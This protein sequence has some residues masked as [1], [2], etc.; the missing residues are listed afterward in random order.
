[1]ICPKCGF[2]QPDDIYCALC[3]VNIERYAHQKRKRRFKTCLLIIAV[4]V[5][6][7]TAASFLTSS[8]TNERVNKVAKDKARMNPALLTQTATYD[9]TSRRE[10]SPPPSRQRSRAL[11]DRGRPAAEQKGPDASLGTTKAKTATTESGKGPSTAIEWFEKGAKLDDDSDAEI[12]CYQKAKELDPTFAP[13]SFRL[14]AIYYREAKYEM[15]DE[16][17]SDFLKNASEQDKETYNI[18]EFY[19]LADVENLTEAISTQAK[20]GNAEKSPTSE[21]KK[22][23]T[24][25]KPSESLDKLPGTPGEEKETTEEVMT[26]VGFSQVD[27]QIM[28]PVLF[29]QSMQA[30]VLVDTGAGITVLS[31][32]LAQE[33][34]LDMNTARSVTLKT[35]AADV[36]ANLGRLDAIQVG[37]LSRQDFPVAIANLPPG[38]RGN[39][40]G[41]LG[42]DFM[43][44]YTIHIDNENSI[45]TLTPKTP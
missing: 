10:A 20:T 16:A 34:G 36:Q 30:R 1:M 18:Y 31:T 45:I 42:M 32:E 27:G 39:F 40:Q 3:G 29:N 43:N 11:R 8:P 7:V 24:E 15:A 41:I 37:T 6:G 14:G 23:T 35:M 12:E 9:N 5:G 2:S 44:H 25:Q 17:F 4:A 19:S 26:V 13:A 21:E 33:L 22:L 38:R 28:V